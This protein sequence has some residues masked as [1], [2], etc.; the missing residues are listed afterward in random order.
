[1][2]TSEARAAIFF[3]GCLLVL[4]TNGS[5]V[6]ASEPKAFCIASTFEFGQNSHSIW[7]KADSCYLM[8][9]TATS[10]PRRLI[11]LYG[12]PVDEGRRSKGA[13]LVSA[14]QRRRNW[15]AD[16]AGSALS[17]S[18]GGSP[19]T[20]IPNHPKN[21][22]GLAGLHDWEHSLIGELETHPIWT[23][24]LLVKK[25]NTGSNS[26][27][28]RLLSIGSMERW[29]G[30]EGNGKILSSTQMDS[31]GNPWN[32]S[33]DNVDTLSRECTERVLAGKVCE[34]PIRKDDRTVEIRL[35]VTPDQ[36]A[37]HVPDACLDG[38][39]EWVAVWSKQG[40]PD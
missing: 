4:S 29:T 18:L 19:V 2:V 32:Q 36:K 28:I 25:D 37:M 35:R 39:F 20:S 24:S 15:F 7:C 31:T 5:S 30:S 40:S 17:V 34:F 16:Q 13:S 9:F 12:I 8:K 6:T 14:I 3:F 26:V 38:R 22:K 21:R 23:D 11:G 27:S 1:M 33:W 10:T